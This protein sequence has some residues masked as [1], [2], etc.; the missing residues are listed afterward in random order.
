[1]FYDTENRN[2]HTRLAYDLYMEY[3]N[4]DPNIH[5]H[6]AEWYF[7][8]HPEEFKTFFIKA[9]VQLRNKKI[10]KILNGRTKNIRN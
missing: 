5:E 7:I 9:N 6:T 8:S 2:K 3:V 10:N 4:N 1:M